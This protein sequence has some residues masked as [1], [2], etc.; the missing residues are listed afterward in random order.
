LNSEVQNQPSE[1]YAS[2]VVAEAG[3]PATSPHSAARKEAIRVN[4]VMIDPV[5]LWPFL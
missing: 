4:V 3:A 1:K 2:P 5:V